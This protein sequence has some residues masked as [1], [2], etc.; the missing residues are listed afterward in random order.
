MVQFDLKKTNIFIRFAPNL[1]E[2]LEEYM[3]VY[4]D[5]NGLAHLEKK[6]KEDNLFSDLLNPPEILEKMVNKIS[7]KFSSNEFPGIDSGAWIGRF[8]GAFPKKGQ[9]LDEHLIP[10]M[11]KLEN[12]LGKE[13]IFKVVIPLK[14]FDDYTKSIRNKEK[15]E[16]NQL[17]LRYIE[18]YRLKLELENDLKDSKNY[19]TKIK[20]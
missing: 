2:E 14:E 8:I 18:S 12:L 13:N 19:K 4:S 11:I 16:R 5:I 6:L 17:V 9:N 3:F 15:D 20:L 7:A 10:W 1:Q